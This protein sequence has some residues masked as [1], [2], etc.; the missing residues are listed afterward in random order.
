M[1]SI[2][3]TGGSTLYAS[4]APDDA[5]FLPYAQGFHPS[6]Q[7]TRLALPPM[8]DLP[9][10]GPNVI[11]WPI[12]GLSRY[13]VGHVLLP[14][15]DL[16][17]L[18]AESGYA[19]MVDVLLTD[20]PD[21][22]FEVPAVLKMQ[23][24]DR[25]VAQADSRSPV[26]VNPSGASDVLYVVTLAD[27]RY[28][29]AGVAASAT[30]ASAPA[31]WGDLISALILAATGQSISAASINAL[32]SGTY[33]APTTT[34]SNN[35]LF[36]E[37]LVFAIDAA[38]LAVNLRCVV[39][40]A[41]GL[42]SVQN[43]TSASTAAA[44]WRST[45]QADMS[46]GGLYHTDAYLPQTF[47]GI[48]YDQ[49]GALSTSTAAAG[50]PTGAGEVAIWLPTGSNNTN[51]LSRFVTDIVAFW[52]IGTYDAVFAGFPDFPL[53]SA[54]GVCRYAGNDT[55]ETRLMADPV[56]YPLPISGSDGSAG[57]GGSPLTTRTT[58]GADT[59]TNTTVIEADGTTGVEF[60]NAVLGDG[61]NQ[62]RALAAAHN[63]W[64]VVSVNSLTTHQQLGDGHKTIAGHLLV[65][66]KQ[67]VSAAGG[68]VV[69][70]LTRVS[71]TFTTGLFLPGRCDWDGTLA[72]QYSFGSLYSYGLASQYRAF[73]VDQQ[74]AGAPAQP[75]RV[76]GFYM[77]TV[78]WGVSGNLTLGSRFVIGEAITG[79]LGGLPTTM[80]QP[81]FAL[82]WPIAAQVGTLY[83]SSSTVYQSTAGYYVP[84]TRF[85]IQQGYTS[86]DGVTDNVPVAMPAGV[87]V[88]TW[89]GNLVLQ[90][91][92]G[93]YAGA[94]KLQT[95]LAQPALIGTPA[96]PPPPA[97]VTA[98]PVPPSVVASPPPP[99]MPQWVKDGMPSFAAQ[100]LAAETAQQFWDIVGAPII[101]SPNNS[102]WRVRPTNLG[103]LSTAVE[104]AL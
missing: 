98:L 31:S 35:N 9:D 65:G 62:I 81:T 18:E 88:P 8:L 3:R 59:E 80:T 77:I 73:A 92:G 91:R 30:G 33:N 54:W 86:I 50:G 84:R 67:T 19:Q 74:T 41:T 101:R 72:T 85:A 95:V 99:A 1:I 48:F 64:G 13:G 4:C 57:T 25:R 10:A 52:G 47:R 61:L 6:R 36:G 7:R 103:S 93:M 39:D 89:G 53:V 11:N 2:R 15:D 75:D 5:V 55:C 12:W 66:D 102:P 40:P 16:T 46:E 97:P 42:I 96:S 68:A 79:D 14:G 87:N 26:D 56:R 82:A 76:H 49:T 34:W 21:D 78:P 17:A 45:W 27:P 32:V 90:F 29:W 63:Q 51:H 38:C 44:S 28:R 94:T 83:D 100:L 58:G 60:H 69:T 23:V 22:P 71:N 70:D 43:A 104:P 24:I 20:A 37:Q